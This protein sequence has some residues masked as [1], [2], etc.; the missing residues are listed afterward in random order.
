MKKYPVGI[1]VIVILGFACIAGY[2]YKDYV[3][4]RNFVLSVNTICDPSSELCFDPVTDYSFNDFPY[5]KVEII[6]KNAPPCLEEHM[7][8]S[9]SCD[10]IDGC[11]VIYCSEETKWEGELCLENGS[12]VSTQTGLILE[13]SDVILEDNI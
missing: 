1:F 3:I 8:E 5:K 12:S 6:A 4:D 13:R 2:R 11:T 10:N 7:C 9:F